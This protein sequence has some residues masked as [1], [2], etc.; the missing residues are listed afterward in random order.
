MSSW[1][2][3]RC[4]IHLLPLP[5][6]IWSMCIYQRESETKLFEQYQQ[7]DSWAQCNTQNSPTFNK[8]LKR[9][10][11]QTNY[12]AILL[13]IVLP[14]LL[15]QTFTFADGAHERVNC[16]ISL[17]SELCYHRLT[18]GNGFGN[19]RTLQLLL[20]FFEPQIELNDNNQHHVS[21]NKTKNQ[22]VTKNK[23]V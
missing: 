21:H 17:L 23:Q 15:Q 5:Y 18:L 4:I 8:L 2:V 13:S 7:M 6:N 11:R 20:Q 10:W 14:Q 22:H 1:D 9:R 16:C 3:P 19:L 12:Y